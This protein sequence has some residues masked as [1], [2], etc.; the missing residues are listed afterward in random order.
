M[1][2][3]SNTKEALGGNS[4][5]TLITPRL[6]KAVLV[7]F[8]P[9]VELESIGLTDDD[10]SPTDFGANAL[11]IIQASGL[12][13]MQVFVS[14]GGYPNLSASLVAEGGGILSAGTLRYEGCPRTPCDVNVPNR[15]WYTGNNSSVVHCGSYDNSWRGFVDLTS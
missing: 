6:L 14:S 15:F 2:R 11:K 12:Y 3:I 8:E 9:R 13:P 7:K 10:M 5:D 1:W 4:N